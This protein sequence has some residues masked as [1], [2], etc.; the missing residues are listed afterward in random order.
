MNAIFPDRRAAGKRLASK[1]G[2]Y[3]SR[4]DVLVLGL[5]RGGVPVAYE[6]ARALRAPLD[7]FIVRKLGYPGQ[8]ELAMGAVASSGK[9]V[10]NDEIVKK[11]PE[12]LVAETL[13][14]EKRK[15]E[16]REKLYRGERSG[17]PLKGRT[18]LVVDDGLATG[19]SM[20]A[21][22][23]ALRDEAPTEIVVAAPVA[24]E[25]TV[26]SLAEVAD[27]VV[28]LE[29]PRPFR[30]VGM[31]YEDF[32]QTSDEEVVRLLRENH[33]KLEEIEVKAHS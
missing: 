2:T 11:V 8:E 20:R 25:D 14:A 18:L 19:A 21:A 15:I 6:V 13:V 23:E 12:W 28:A 31:W 29:T 17:L 26:K 3:A 9:V 7:V 5:P 27:A 30:G 4:K 24:P 32:R 22:V 33:S 16:A 1:L 10:W